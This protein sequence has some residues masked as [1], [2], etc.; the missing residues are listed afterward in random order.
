MDVKMSG[1]AKKS[2]K[3]KTLGSMVTVPILAITLGACA[4]DEPEESNP[5]SNVPQSE[6]QTTSATPPAN[7]SESATA[8]AGNGRESSGFK[9]PA[10]AVESFVTQVLRGRYKEACLA[11]APERVSESEAKARC[12][13]PQA[14][15]MLKSLHDAW[16]KPGVKLPPE[17]KVEV[18]NL[19][20]EGNTARVPD[21][22][23][24]LD[25]RTLRELE[26]LGSSGDTKNFNFSLGLRKHD[27]T[28]HIN[29]MD[30]SF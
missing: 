19:T 5:R 1:I 9:T 7:N 14:K 18:T 21:S 2:G 24:T 15:K 30:I 26:L 16:A 8:R 13:G 17:A 23:I 3:N 10:S 29:K 4:V 28:W 22:Q 6:T 27:K 12:S 11:S 25:G 20:K